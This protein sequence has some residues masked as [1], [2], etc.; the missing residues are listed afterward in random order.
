MSN[1]YT[2]CSK[3][4][5]FDGL[6]SRRVSYPQK[7]WITSVLLDLNCSESTCHNFSMNKICFQILLLTFSVTQSFQSM[8]AVMTKHK[9]S[10]E[11][12]Q[13]ARFKIEKSLVLARK[14]KGK[15]S[16]PRTTADEKKVYDELISAYERNDELSFQSRFQ[17]IVTTYPRG[18]FAD[19]A[20]FLAG[21]LS[22][23]NK[24]YGRAIKNFS[25][26]I[27]EYRG[28]NRYR[29]AMFAKAAAYRKMNLNS[30]ARTVFQEVKARYPGSPEAKR[31]DLE[32]RM[33]K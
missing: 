14:H 11:A 2:K 23:A 27:S 20:Y 17:Y 7:M 8:A 18:V 24:Q 10:P 33:V 16:A 29:S 9:L 1:Y 31:A 5:P 28:S 19:D 30:H 4:Y 32:L 21:M 6:R 3:P 26:V 12:E 15:M 25:K 22:L 13:K